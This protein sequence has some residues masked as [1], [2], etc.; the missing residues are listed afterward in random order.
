MIKRFIFWG[1]VIALFCG[2][3]RAYEKLDGKQKKENK[4]V[5]ELVNT[6]AA[7]VVDLH[8]C[9]MSLTM[10]G[11]SDFD[12]SFAY[13]VMPGFNVG[14]SLDARNLLGTEQIDTSSPQVFFKYNLIPAQSI[15][16]LISVG[17]DNRGVSRESASV[18]STAS[19]N[20]RGYYV[21]VS[22]NKFYPGVGV[23][24]GINVNRDINNPESYKSSGFGG[25]FCKVSDKVGLVADVEN[26]GN[27]VKTITNAGL[28]Y[29]VV[30]YISVGFDFRNIGKSDEKSIR[31]FKIDFYGVF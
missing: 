24:C 31:T 29:T 9:V 10:R 3:A 8:S 14:F 19:Q 23:H 18:L 5:V 1:L 27:S 21:V 4:G 11:D 26:I 17:Y 20:N 16:P 22:Q 15:Y 2:Q 12:A 28:R 25:I 6:P 30:D 13:G 7:D